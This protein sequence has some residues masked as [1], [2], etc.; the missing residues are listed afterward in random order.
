MAA[1]LTH[2]K[3]MPD[4]LMPRLD[5]AVGR[6]RDRFEFELDTENY[7]SSGSLNSEKGVHERY[8][9]VTPLFWAWPRVH[10]ELYEREID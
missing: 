3:T 6:S 1:L 8:G 9:V 4:S 10:E 7:P 5:A 2:I